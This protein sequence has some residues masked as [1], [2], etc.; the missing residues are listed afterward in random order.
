M[1]TRPQ[2]GFTVDWYN[3][4]EKYHMRTFPHEARLSSLPADWQR[5]LA[6]LWRLE[7]DVNNG[8]CLQVLENWGRESY[9]YASQALKKIG[10]RKMADIVDRR[11]SLVDEHFEPEGKSLDVLRRLLPNPVIDSDGTLIKDVGSVLPDPI[12]ERINELSYEFMKY[13]D[14]LSKLGLQYYR[15]NIEDDGPGG[16]RTL[17]RILFLVLLLLKASGVGAVWFY[18]GKDRDE[19][20]LGG[21]GTNGAFFGELVNQTQG[22]LQERYG[23]P[24]NEWDGYRPLGSKVP[25]QLPEGRIRTLLFRGRGGLN[26]AEGTVMVWLVERRRGWVCFESV[27]FG[28]NVWF[29]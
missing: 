25:E 10:A 14:D 29:P 28:G 20:L 13:P 7:A 17:I 19:F 2:K 5:E 1:I 21:F 8:A 23:H 3:A 18:F 26:N 15:S 24:E 11:Q 12:V 16:A 27:W 9:V 22:Q 4:T 6:A